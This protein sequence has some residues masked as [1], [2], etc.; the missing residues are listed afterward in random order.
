MVVSALHRDE[1]IGKFRHLGSCLVWEVCRS[2]VGSGLSFHADSV[3][4]YCP[5]PKGGCFYL[6][7]GEKSHGCIVDPHYAGGPSFLEFMK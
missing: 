4:I 7:K 3:P 5:F 1:I 2:N 6:E